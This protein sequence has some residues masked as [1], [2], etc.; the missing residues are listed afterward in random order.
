MIIFHE[1]LPGSGKSYEAAV[2]QIIPALKKGRVVYAYI[3]G[4]NHDKFSEVTGLSIDTV[5][6]LLIQLT[7]EQVKEIFDHVSNDS[8]VII[9]ELQDFFPSGRRTLDAGI[10][11]FVTQHRHRGI[12]VVCMGQDNR[13]CHN[14]WKRRIDTLI[15]FT[16]RDAVGSPTTYT[17][18]TFKQN[19]GKFVELRS[20]KGSYDSQYFGLYASHASDVSSI[21][22][23][24]DDRSNIFKSK[25][26]TFWLPLFFCCFGYGMYYLW[27][28]FHNSPVNI[29]P[30]SP[31]A[32]SVNPVS[33]VPSV[34]LTQ[35]P[36]NS[37]AP[38][39]PPVIETKAVEY[40][41][42]VEKYLMDYRPRLS[43]LIVSSDKKNIIVR[44]DF[45]KDDRIIDTLDAKQ[46]KEFGYFI[47][48]KSFG[49]LMT[50]ASKSYPVTMWKLDLQ[51][52][53]PDRIKP[54][55]RDSD[56]QIASK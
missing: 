46:L 56:K 23:H 51:R 26:F 15:T 40:A 49:I 3:E 4:L 13:D 16:K 5:N 18:K 53:T 7:K 11:E 19:A 44:I 33:S 45:Y 38:V 54:A 47:E 35:K 41:G 43:G 20:G 36:I 31:A 39:L 24:K 17:W 22:A 12:D 6:E 30:P 29:S 32:I 2:N 8:L 25:T 50:K 52:N 37:S 27:G 9:D 55:L 42:F 34:P 21:D 1:G 28:F 10:T 14:L 48:V